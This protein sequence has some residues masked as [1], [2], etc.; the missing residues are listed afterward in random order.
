MVK[1]HLLRVFIARA[2]PE[3]LSHVSPAD[4][5]EYVLP[6]LNGLGT[7]PGVSSSLSIV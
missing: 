1:L 4:A 5:V 2:L 6:L 7:D 3:Y